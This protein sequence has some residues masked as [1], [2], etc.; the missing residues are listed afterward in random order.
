MRGGEREEKGKIGASS[1][2]S[3]PTQAGF[4]DLLNFQDP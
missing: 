1:G 2:T 4:Q 3:C